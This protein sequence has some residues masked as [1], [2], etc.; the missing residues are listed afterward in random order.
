MLNTGLETWWL[1]TFTLIT[2]FK[3]LWIEW[4][5]TVIFGSIFNIALLSE[6]TNPL[7]KFDQRR[8]FFKIQGLL[9]Y[10]KLICELKNPWE[11]IISYKN[12]TEIHWTGEWYIHISL[13]SLYTL[14][15]RQNIQFVLYSLFAFIVLFWLCFQ[16]FYLH[17]LFECIST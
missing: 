6:R 8:T 14:L 10:I 16:S 12:G 7:L 17:Y 9:Y 2:L 3:Y 15:D 13:P 5:K 4:G 1:I 11:K